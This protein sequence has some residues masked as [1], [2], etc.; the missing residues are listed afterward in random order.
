MPEISKRALPIAI[1]A[2]TPV[3]LAVK[4]YGPGV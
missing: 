3:I 4:R 1:R 2:I